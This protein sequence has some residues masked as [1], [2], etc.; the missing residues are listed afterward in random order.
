VVSLQFLQLPAIACIQPDVKFTTVFNGVTISTLIF[1]IFCMSTYHLG[2]KTTVARE[3][4]E[5]RQRFKS[6]CLNVFIWGLFLIYPQVSSTTLLIFACT[7]LEDGTAW[8]MADYRIQCWT[9]EHRSY[10]G[11]GIIWAILF[12][13]GIPAGMIYFMWRSRVPELASWKSEC[14]W[15]RSIVHRAMVIGASPRSESFDPD[16]ISTD[17][18]TVEHLRV[19]HGLFVSPSSTAAEEVLKIK[20]PTRLREQEQQHGSGLEQRS[21]TVRHRA[22]GLS[23]RFQSDFPERPGTAGSDVVLPDDVPEDDVLPDSSNDI[24]AEPTVRQLVGGGALI[25]TGALGVPQA[26]RLALLQSQAAEP[27]A[28]PSAPAARRRWSTRLQRGG[29]GSSLGLRPRSSTENWFLSFFRRLQEEIGMEV[30]RMATQRAKTIRRTLSS[31]LYSN[32]RVLLLKSLLEWAKHDKHCLV[33][34][35]RHNQM[36]WR[37]HYEWQA[38]RTGNIQLGDHDSAEQAGALRLRL[39][40]HSCFRLTRAPHNSLQQVRL[41]VFRLLRARV[42]LGGRRF[43]PKAVCAC[44]APAAAC[45]RSL[46][47]TARS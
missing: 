26:T 40:R 29:R 4:P 22:E 44:P 21:P 37:T 42:V 8:L 47:R 7:D 28:E 14:A 3:D 36:R 43:R 33:S 6:R 38:L 41:L 10:V 5:R 19:L 27:G 1:C 39:R 11:I 23:V 34:E 46:T 2:Q 30:T 31:I 18:I 25:T 20:A 16:S 35:P 9:P 17:S 24:Q 12:P 32:E 15:L 13:F 45:L